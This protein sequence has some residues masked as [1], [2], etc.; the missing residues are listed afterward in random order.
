MQA[1]QEEI[2]KWINT[3]GGQWG[4]VVEDLDSDK[5]IAINENQFFAAQSIIKVPIMAAVF[6]AYEH[7][8][9][10]LSDKRPIRKEELVSGSGVLQHLSPGTEL[11][12]YD[13]MMLMIIQSDN[14]ATNI[15]ID[16]VGFDLINQ[17]MQ[18]G[19]MKDSC[20]K[21]KLMIY[22]HTEKDVENYLNAR[23]IHEFYKNIA[24][25][26]IISGYSCLQMIE[27]L[28]KQ[29][30]RNAI[31]NDLPDQQSNIIGSLP[32]WQLANKTGW[33]THYQH[34]VGILYVKNHSAVITILSKG[35]GSKQALDVS[36]KI[37][38]LVYDYLNA[39][40]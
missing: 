18:E 5:K 6:A 31:P 3:G 35:I 27:I 22:P 2:T 9:F 8:A 1:V 12:I 37:G 21:K 39:K 30:V 26:K 25:G 34:D 38:R 14:T 16:L 11:S 36:G 23:D 10:F 29:Q 7:G 33:D 4:I 19:G 17:V 40:D 13:L 28:K 15:L 20:L 24:L 32:E